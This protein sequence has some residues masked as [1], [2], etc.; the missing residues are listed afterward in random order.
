MRPPQLPVLRHLHAR[1]RAIVGAAVGT[2]VGLLLPHSF[3]LTVRAVIGWD[4]GAILYLTLAIVMAARATSASM[5]RRAALEDEGRWVFLGVMAGAAFFSMFAILGVM[6]EAKGMDGSLMIPLTLLAGVTI[7]L[8]WLLAHTV[9][10]LHYAHGYFKDLDE[11][12]PRGLD[13]PAED[14]DPDYWDFLYFSFVVGM[15]AQVSDVQVLTQ[16][17][18]RLVLAHGILSFMFNT[19]VLALSINLFA[20]FFQDLGAGK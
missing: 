10:A 16:S 15:T 9:F 2:V 7:L 11:N 19:V 13:F 4:A 5:R 1:P 6:R 18:R 20:A 14:E 12:R 3:S 8:S 17:W